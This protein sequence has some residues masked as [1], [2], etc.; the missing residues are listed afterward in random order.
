[1]LKDKKLLRKFNIVDVLVIV[2]VI[3]LIMGAYI[4]FKKFNSKT[5]ETS[6]SNIEYQ[7]TVNNIREYTVNAFKIGDTI[8]D[9]QSGVVIGTV[10]EVL[11]K[12]A[13]TYESTSKGEVIKTKNPYRYDM[14]LTIETPGTVEADAYYAN[15]SI[16]LKVNSTKAIETKYVK[17][18]GVISDITIK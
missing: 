6:E 4:K 3:L 17:T 9:S 13:E 18:S 2:L 1:M 11:Q 5:D 7:I 8:Y 16:E 12:E 14:I 10:K 15:K